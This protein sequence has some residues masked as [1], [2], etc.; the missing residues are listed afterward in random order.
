MARCLVVALLALVVA[1][2]A[3]G[4]GG[5]NGAGELSFYPQ[6]GILWRDLYPNNFVDLDP[7]PGLRAFTV[8]ARAGQVRNRAP[9]GIGAE[10]VPV[11]P[12][13]GGVVEC[14]VT[15]VLAAEDPDFDIVRI[16]TAGSSTASRSRGAERGAVGRAAKGLRAEGKE[17]ALR[18][19]AERRAARRAADDRDGGLT[20]SRA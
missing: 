5:A 15:T 18:S 2:S 11:S 6:A 4:A 14:R 7:G 8:V 13:P 20:A 12:S 3:A 19:H 17:R 10:L 9:R 16:G 1:V